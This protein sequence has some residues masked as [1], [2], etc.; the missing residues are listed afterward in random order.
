MGG[1]TLI[2]TIRDHFNIS[3]CLLSFAL[4][5][6]LPTMWMPN[7]VYLVMVPLFVLFRK[8]QRFPWLL[9]RL[10]DFFLLRRS[11]HTSKFAED[12]L[13]IEDDYCSWGPDF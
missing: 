11:F 5:D 13:K 9:S 7:Q 12:F 10:F 1:T 6:L 3:V 4:V 8:S 2:F